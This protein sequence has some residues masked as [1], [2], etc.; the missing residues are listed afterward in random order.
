MGGAAACIFAYQLLALKV[1]PH[2][3]GPP[4]EGMEIQHTVIP[5]HAGRRKARNNTS[6][7]VTMPVSHF[8]IVMRD[9]RSLWNGPPY[10][11]SR[12]LIKYS[13]VSNAI[14]VDNNVSCP[15]AFKQIFY[16]P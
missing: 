15:A 7:I 2:Y 5:D 9:Y 8:I 10:D 13:S 4:T 14:I 11:R 12:S 6:S 3:H 1:A 16:R